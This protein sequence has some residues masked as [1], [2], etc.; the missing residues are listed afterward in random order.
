MSRAIAD[1]AEDRGTWPAGVRI[2]RH[3]GRV[4]ESGSED[5]RGR[6][7]A[8]AATG[9]Y[10]LAAI[11]IT[12]PLLRPGYPFA[13]DMSFGPV[14]RVPPEA[15]GLGG[16]FGRRLPVFLV[17]AGASSVVSPAMLARLIL[18]AIPYLGGLGMHRLSPAT[19]EPSRYFAG[20][21]YAVNPFVFER[22]V[23]GH[24]HILLGYALLPWALPALL[25]WA[26]GAE[27]G[28]LIRAGLWL[29]ILGS[30]SFAV[31]SIAFFVVLLAVL[32]LRSSSIVIRLRATAGILLLFL[33]TNATWLVAA[34]VRLGDID[35][36]TQLDFRAF[37]VR[38][39][40]SWAAAGNVLRLTGFF[41]EDFRSPALSTTAGLIL[42]GVVAVLVALGIVAAWRSKCLGTRMAPFLVGVG[43]IAVMAAL[44]ERAPILGPALGWLYPR[45]PGMQIFRESQKIAG[46]VVLVYAI[47][48]S[49]GADVVLTSPEKD[50]E[51]ESQPVGMRALAATIVM[52]AVVV[53]IPLAWTPGVFAGAGG[54]VVV[55][56]YPAGW[57]EAE[58][59]L[60]AAGDGRTLVLPWHVHMPLSFTNG[61]TNL[62]PA[63]DFFTKDLV[64]ASA[65]EFPGFML[66]PDDPVETYVR[67]AITQGTS[68]SDFGA[69]VNPL[70][71]DSILLLKEADWQ[72]YAFLD[73]Q[74][75][76]KKVLENENVIIYE[77]PGIRESLHRLA[78]AGELT[79]VIP[80]DPLGTAYLTGESPGAGECPEAYG[81]VIHQEIYSYEIPGAGCW[82]LPEQRSSGWSPA[83]L[84][85]SADSAVST[86]V[87][88]GSPVK[89]TYWPATYALGGHAVSLVSIVVLA[90]LLVSGSLKRRRSEEDQLV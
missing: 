32:I 62:N 66:P 25:T 44:G 89:M 82:L 68:R 53:L 56:E 27:R 24:W 78:P 47:F 67:A 48:G 58:V 26:R 23:A 90:V 87:R 50:R 85:G 13:F 35:K 41:R 49:L 75:D 42:F 29:G 10:A 36:F 7:R 77:A 64:Q 19:R 14:M 5:R 2:G 9:V 11:A 30:V 43:A 17:L 72:E 21:L 74:R 38:G 52:A 8:L 34:L 61:R 40:S 83:H 51:P 39:E 20:L 59:A 55:S 73:S 86:A 16:D 80:P 37:L 45:I 84:V 46:L 1:E 88:T 63:G 28:S 3:L 12:Y 57:H 54:R 69:V 60:G 81:A 33:A 6:L 15:Y 76:L 79:S 4:A 22:L 31:A 70:G 18:V 71:V 65:I